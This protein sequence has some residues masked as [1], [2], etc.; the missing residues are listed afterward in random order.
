ME[1]DSS[2]LGD[3]NRLQQPWRWKQIAA[4]LAMEKDSK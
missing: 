2:S 3:G 4:T 1:T